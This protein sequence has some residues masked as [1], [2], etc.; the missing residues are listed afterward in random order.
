M[1]KNPNSRF[2]KARL[3]R[4]LLWPGRRHFLGGRPA[5]EALGGPPPRRVRGSG[6][7]RVDLHPRPPRPPR[8]PA[9]RA[10]RVRTVLAGD[11]PGLRGPAP[12]PAE[13]RIPRERDLGPGGDPA[14]LR[15][16]P[17]GREG[18]GPGLAAA[19]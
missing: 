13:W 1:A 15:G 19:G 6:G 16:G 3:R 11:A 7:S 2:G 10:L 12:A 18:G 17:L 4:H 8:V 9:G 5:E 14:V